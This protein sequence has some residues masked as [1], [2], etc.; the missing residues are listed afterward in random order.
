MKTPSEGTAKQ[1]APKFIKALAGTAH[2][3]PPMWLMRQAGRYLAE[4]REVRA[5]AGSFLTLSVSIWS[6]GRAKGRTLSP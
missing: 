2:K 1:D 4:Y 3:A 6:F 5:Q